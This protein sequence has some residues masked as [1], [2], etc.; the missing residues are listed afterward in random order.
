MTSICCICLESSEMLSFLDTVDSKNVKYLKKLIFCVP[1]ETW[2]AHYQICNTCISQL[3]LVYKFV[4]CCIESEK[5]RKLGVV[6]PSDIPDND[7][8]NKEA[9]D[10][11]FRC[12]LCEKSFRQ[13]KY[14][15]QHISIIHPHESHL[16]KDEEHV[17]KTEENDN[18][19]AVQVKEDC[20]EHDKENEKI[21]DFKAEFTRKVDQNDEDQDFTNDGFSEHSDIDSENFEQDSKSLEIKKRRLKREPQKCDFCDE[22]FRKRQ[23][24]NMHMRLEHTFEKPFAC[25]QCDA[26]YMNRYSLQIHS[27]KHNNEKPFICATCGKCF[28][29]SADLSHHSKI[30]NSERAYPCPMCERSFK[31]HSNLRTHRLQMHLDPSEWKFHCNM[32]EKKF[33]IRGNLMKH[34]KRHA[35]IKEFDCHICQ[36]KFI[37]KAELTLHLNTHTNQRLFKCSVCEKDYKN[38]EGLRRHMKVVHDQGN[39]KAPKTV[40]KYLCPMC[41][42][43]FASVNRLQRHIFTHTGEKP[44]KCDYCQKRFIDKYGRKVHYKKDHNIEIFV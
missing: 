1:N 18:K 9:S 38:R 3:E 16:V 43:I 12:N 2:K 33:P 13:K 37:N 42:K 8:I 35:G 24:W 14:L 40:K 34:L 44:F 25:D 10:E 19:T 5:F 28:V 41:P 30:H 31:T 17:T 6:D 36:K 7:I 39:W 32:C 27:R 4:L 22:T 11:K 29:S 21:I 23:D 15:S 26:R 20:L